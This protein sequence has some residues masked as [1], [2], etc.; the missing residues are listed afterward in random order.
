M[1]TRDTPPADGNRQGARRVAG[2]TDRS[3]VPGG[4][5]P[6]DIADEFLCEL[7]QPAGW[8]ALFDTWAAARKVPAALRE[9]A[10]SLVMLRR[11]GGVS[12]IVGAQA[13]RRTAVAA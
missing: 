6:I 2:G 8:L 9:A 4:L 13:R 12:A 1:V 10:R 7:V 5:G 3:T 11:I